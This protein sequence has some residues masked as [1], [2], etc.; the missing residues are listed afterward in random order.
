MAKIDVAQ[1]EDF[2]TKIT[3]LGEILTT[4]AESI[5]TTLT[6]TLPESGI[7]NPAISEKFA[8]LGGQVSTLKNN[9]SSIESEVTTALNTIKANV[10]QETEAIKTSLGE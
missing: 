10:E 3:N 8:T 2:K 6:V 5:N 4:C 7:N 1:I 9:W